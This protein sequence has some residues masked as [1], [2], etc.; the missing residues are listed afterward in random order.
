MQH[1]HNKLAFAL[2]LGLGT[3]LALGFLS[4]VQAQDKKSDASGTWTWTVPGR[5]GGPDR[6][7]TLKLKVEGDKVTGKIAAPA[8]GGETRETDIKDGQ[9]KGDEIS[10]KVVREV[11]GNEITS[12][13]HGKISGDTI[14][15][16]VEVER[17]GEN[18]SR[19]WEAKRGSE[20]K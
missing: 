13:Y 10:F 4:Q 16:K 1:I 3:I 7:M 5:N 8:R 14:K 18:Q 11:N 19:D 6:K 12:K 17:N 20:T 2:K 15:G 9:I